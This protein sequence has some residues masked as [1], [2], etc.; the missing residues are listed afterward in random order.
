[1]TKIAYTGFWRYFDPDTLPLTKIFR[2]V[3]DVE[4]TDPKHADYVLYSV[5]SEK[6]WFVPNDCIKIFY[7]GENL[8][9]DFNACDYAIGFD[10][11]DFGDRYLRFPL[12]YLY[13]D[14]NELMEKKHLCDPAEVK[15]SK[16]DFCSITVSNSNR[17]PM[18]KTLYDALF[19]YKQVDSGGKWMNN[20]GGR[21]D[22]KHDFDLKHKFSIVCENTSYPGYTTEKLVQAFAAGCI[23]VYWGDPTVG[24]VFNKKA[25]I[26]VPDY[27]SVDEVLE[28][29]K[30]IDAD[31]NLYF[32]MLR[33]PALADESYS[34]VNQLEVL[35][36]FVSNIF[37]QPKEEAYRRSRYH[38]GT[39]Y[40]KMRQRQAK[41]T[42][43]HRTFWEDAAHQAYTLMHPKEKRK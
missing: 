29:V 12:Y 32:S 5:F 38:Y 26:N 33:E 7:T 37:S 36:Q 24:K 20:V 16:T 31:D 8:T 1:M 34:K 22:N 11:L 18:F 21:V 25:F 19:S 14:I 28:R 43:F 27:A 35:R 13:V 42:V 6:H 15:A 17:N 40:I 30:A 3:C 4:V 10:W 9:P 23:P 39:K 2:E 41:T